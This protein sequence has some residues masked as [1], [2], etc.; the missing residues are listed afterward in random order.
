M[1]WYGKVITENDPYPGPGCNLV[2]ENDE[3]HFV[4]EYGQELSLDIMEP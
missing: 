1:H 2:R 4:D 3:W